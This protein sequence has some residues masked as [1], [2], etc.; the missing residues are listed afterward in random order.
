ML[1][2]RKAAQVIRRSPENIQRSGQ[3]G[4]PVGNQEAVPGAA[5]IAHAAVGASL[6]SEIHP[7]IIVAENHLQNPQRAGVGKSGL[8][9]IS[10]HCHILY[11]PG[12]FEALVFLFEPVA[13]SSR[14]NLLR[15][16]LLLQSGNPLFQVF[17][18]FPIGHHA[19]HEIFRT[20]N[21]LHQLP[22][23]LRHLFPSLLKILFQ[24]LQQTEIGDSR[25]PLLEIGAGRIVGR[26]PHHRG[27]VACPR[28]GRL[29]PGF[30]PGNDLIQPFSVI[31]PGGFENFPDHRKDKFLAG[32]QVF[33]PDT[34]HPRAVIAP[35]L[36]IENLN[37]A[38]DSAASGI[39]LVKQLS[40]AVMLR[41]HVTQNRFE[42]THVRNQ[43]VRN[44][45]GIKQQ[46]QIGDAVGLHVMVQHRGVSHLMGG[47]VQLHRFPADIGSFQHRQRS[48]CLRVVRRILKFLQMA[49]LLHQF[50]HFF[51][52]Q[53]SFVGGQR[54]LRL[55][56]LFRGQSL[57]GNSH[58]NSGVRIFQKPGAD[59]FLKVTLTCFFLQRVEGIQSLQM[60][61]WLLLIVQPAV[62]YVDAVHQ[63]LGIGRVVGLPETEFQEINAGGDGS[64]IQSL[65]GQLLQRFADHLQKLLFPGQFAVFHHHREE[66]LVDS[67]VIAALHILADAGVQKCLFQR[68][69]RGGKQHIIQHLKGSTQFHI[70]AVAHHHAAA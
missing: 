58:H 61:K 17:V 27:G 15:I 8:P 53:R 34:E 38:A 9:E 43:I 33:C 28:Q 2:R 62:K 66:R 22:E 1:I 21:N 5:E 14:G 44:L 36:L 11:L 41:I 19:D 64:L 24:I 7:Q 54:L 59:Q 57:P 4:I 6:D 32:R 42:K 60:D 31:Q 35:V 23:I 56:L 37:P 49:G 45:P 50:L 48:Q 68:R 47:I 10:S 25:D 67:V 70:Q 52:R 16:Q 3:M 40:V 63:S 26:Y 18:P 69:S 12:S 39:D 13:D 30:L 51:R 20:E 65:P 46:R 29:Q 55:F